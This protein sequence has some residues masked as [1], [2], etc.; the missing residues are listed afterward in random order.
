M[1][2]PHAT[3]AIVACDSLVVICRGFFLSLSYF[4][5]KGIFCNKQAVSSLSKRCQEELF[6]TCLSSRLWAWEPSQGQLPFPPLG[7]AGWYPHTCL[8]A[9]S[10]QHPLSIIT[11]Q[12]GRESPGEPETGCPGREGREGIPEEMAF[13][14]GLG[15]RSGVYQEG[16]REGILGRK[17][18]RQNML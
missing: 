5:N 14:Q 3:P 16:R 1:C 18:H 4:I 10:T 17:K 2:V 11:S 15:G 6:L 8:P 13:G 12:W 9:L 7:A